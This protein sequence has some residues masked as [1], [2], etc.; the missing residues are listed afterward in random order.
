MGLSSR[1]QTIAGGLAHRRKPP[2]GADHQSIVSSIPKG[3]TA[4]VAADHPRSPNRSFWGCST[5]AKPPPSCWCAG[6]DRNHAWRLHPHYPNHD[7][8]AAGVSVLRN[9]LRRGIASRRHPMG[10]TA[11]ER[12]PSLRRNQVSRRT[13]GVRGCASISRSKSNS[14]EPGW[15]PTRM[16]GAGAPDDIDKAHQTQVWLATSDEQAA[17]VSGRYFFHQTQRDPDPATT[18]IERQDLLLDLCRKVS[19]TALT[20]P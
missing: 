4:A 6:A 12:L 11:V 10:E 17:T 20:P 3:S 8:E 2:T 1:R 18:D 15:V 7:A 16:G 5:L 9:A 13:T 19:G 14:L